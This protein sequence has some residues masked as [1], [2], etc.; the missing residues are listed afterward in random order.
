[1]DLSDVTEA[2]L[3]LIT[4]E[5]TVERERSRLHREILAAYE[6]GAG[7]TAI[8]KATYRHYTPEHCARIRKGQYAHLIERD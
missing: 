3:A 7:N 5:Q 2:A 6:V 8:S 1:M 4:A